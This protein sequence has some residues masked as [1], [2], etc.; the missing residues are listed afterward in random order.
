MVDMYYDWWISMTI[1]SATLVYNAIE[2]SKFWL[3][4]N[5]HVENDN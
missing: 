2:F 1:L 5:F 3:E 4:S